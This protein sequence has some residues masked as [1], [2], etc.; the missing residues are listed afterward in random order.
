[1]NR[2][3]KLI[4]FNCAN[5]IS[6]RVGMLVG[7][8]KVLDLTKA[9]KYHASLAMQG[10][11]MLGLIENNGAETVSILKGILDKGVADEDLV[12]FSKINLKAPLPRPKRN[13]ICVGKNYLDHVAEVAAVHNKSGGAPSTPTE[14]PKYAQFFTKAPQTVIPSGGNVEA[15]PAVTRVLDYEVELA[16]IIGKTGRDIS[17]ENA[18]AHVFG[19][20]V[21]NDITARDVQKKHNQWFKG[22]SL[23]STCPLGPCIVPASQIDASDLPIKMWINGEKRQDS[24]TSNMIFNVATI[25]EQLS[26]GFTLYPGD[27]I[28]TG[29]PQGVGFA[30]QPP[31]VLKP[32]DLMEAEIE[33]IGRLVNRVIA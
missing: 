29:T 17:K 8:K 32:G 27:I 28:L 14:L 24:R 25:I 22:K 16:V 13:V 5:N 19:Y 1:M 20:T 12:D 3:V 30:M 33:G 6:N 9:G 23:D 11:S 15:H 31:Q 7:E 2:A 21:A 4:T 18:L 26:A 10:K